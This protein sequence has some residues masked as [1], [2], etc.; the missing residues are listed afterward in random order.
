[1]DFW[2]QVILVALAGYGLVSLIIL[3]A[4]NFW[5]RNPAL[6]GQAPEFL[7]LLFLIRNQEPVL[8]PLMRQVLALD[9]WGLG[10]EPAFE[11]VAIDTG[12][13]DASWEVLEGLSKSLPG[14]RAARIVSEDTGSGLPGECGLFLCRSRVVL[15]FD[16]R[17]R[18]NLP[19]ILAELGYFLR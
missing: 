11:V 15:A 13:T 12:S 5:L 19:E 4:S 3:I 1:M 17:G 14:M 8:E 16:L 10:G 6:K 9:C 18:V 7:S 2:L